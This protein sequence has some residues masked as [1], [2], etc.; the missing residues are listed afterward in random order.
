MFR[1]AADNVDADDPK[2]D[3]SAI[4]YSGTQVRDVACTSMTAT[5]AQH[6]KV[7]RRDEPLQFVNSLRNINPTS[8]LEQQ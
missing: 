6:E 3:R 4:A 8:A 1:M 5:E 7:V 2:P